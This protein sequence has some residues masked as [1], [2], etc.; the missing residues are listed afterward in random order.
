MR[1]ITTSRCPASATVH[2]GLAALQTTLVLF[3]TES[4]WRLEKTEYEH[5]KHSM[6]YNIQQEIS[7]VTA[8]VEQFLA[9]TV[10]RGAWT[11][12]VV[13][14][15]AHKPDTQDSS[16]WRP[17]KMAPHHTHLNSALT[18]LMAG[19]QGEGKPEKRAWSCEASGQSEEGNRNRK[20]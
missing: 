12:N 1:Q 10:L 6:A 15:G 17:D 2:S 8:D 18:G 3:Y 14:H 9:A 20:V 5:T 16:V 19:R 13:V 11:K 4:C 7:R